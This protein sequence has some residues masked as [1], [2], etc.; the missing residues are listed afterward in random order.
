MKAHTE[1]LQIARTSGWVSDPTC[2]AQL[3]FNYAEEV[4][5]QKMVEE[6]ADMAGNPFIGS[7][8]PG[9]ED[10]AD[11]D[12]EAEDVLKSLSPEEQKMVLAKN[13]PK[14]IAALLLAKVGTN[15]NGNGKTPPPPPAP[16]E[17]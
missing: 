1:S 7:D 13:D 3:G 16:E 15:G 11:M 10:E 4:R 8:A 2:A 17:D 12:K 14:E 6:E 9:A 5:K